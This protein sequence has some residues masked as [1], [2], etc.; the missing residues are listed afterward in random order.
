MV[1]A[2]EPSSL[3]YTMAMRDGYVAEHRLVMAQY[4][5]RCLHKGE[6]VHHKN[7][8][9]ADNRIENLELISS[10]EN[11]VFQKQCANCELKKQI[12]LLRWQIQE[13]SKQLQSKLLI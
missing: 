7:E 5:G 6:I 11:L 10:L 8:N 9:R 3:F 13:L 12:K 1:I 2:I 4:L